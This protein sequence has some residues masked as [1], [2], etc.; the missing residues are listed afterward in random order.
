MINEVGISE[1]LLTHNEKLCIILLLRLLL[2]IILCNI[3]II[4][5]IKQRFISAIRGYKVSNISLKSI[6]YESIKAIFSSIADSDVIS[7]AEIAAKTGLSLVTVG[8]IVD[9]LLDNEIISQV[10]SLSTK[11]GRRAGLIGINEMK[12]A[13]IL[14]LTT[15]DFTFSLVN[16]QMAE[17]YCEVFK[18]KPSLSYQENL[19]LFLESI[20]EYIV[21][22]KNPLDCIGVGAAVPGVYNKSTDSVHFERIPELTTTNLYSIISEYFTDVPILI[23]SHTNAAAK[24]NFDKVKNSIDKSMLYWYIGNDYISGAFSVFGNQITGKNSIACDFGSLLTFD[25]L[26]LEDKLSLI[27]SQDDYVNALLP[28]IY[29]VIKVLNPDTIILDFDT[30]YKIDEILSEIKIAL[31]M[32]YRIKEN[33]LPDIIRATTGCRSAYRGLILKLRE[34]ILD[35][36]VFDD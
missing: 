25:G 11:V 8:K 19:I 17:I 10:K 15:Y 36:I 12:F 35:K 29:N 4:F 13:V 26:T 5:A 27:K 7:R 2:V 18:Y 34:L 9:A 14:D 1:T 32:K 3:F 22:K 28:S 31:L 20:I 23:D 33:T 30:D 6:K 24:Y 21:T 16:L